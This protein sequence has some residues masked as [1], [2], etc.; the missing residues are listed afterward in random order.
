MRLSKLLESIQIESVLNLDND[1]EMEIDELCVD[2]RKVKKN[3]LFFCLTGGN[4]DGHLFAGEATLRGATALVV[5]KPLEIP[6]LQIIVK[7]TREALS[8]MASAFYGEPSKRLKIIGITGTNGK[9]T[10][11]HMLASILEKSGKKTGIIGTL[12]AQIDGE[13][14][15][16]QLTTPDPIELQKT[17]AKMC[18]YLLKSF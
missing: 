1:T 18:L 17:L 15:C 13:Y 3:S 5:E 14:E 7:N 12:G 4:S 9:T 6:L 10:T 16:T 11:A 2:S 8:K